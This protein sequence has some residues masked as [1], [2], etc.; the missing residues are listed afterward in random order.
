MAT[1]DE[2]V[3]K[4]CDN[5]KQLF[6]ESKIQLHEAYCLR[7]IRKCPNCDMFVDKRE[8]EEH[9][10]EFHTKVTCEKCGQSVEN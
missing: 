7:N 5:C 6:P 4:P 9:K 10:E 3:K 1:Y 2:E 8:L